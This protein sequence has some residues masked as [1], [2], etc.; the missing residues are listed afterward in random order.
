[1][2][3]IR[4][5]PSIL[6]ADFSR[7]QEHIDEAGNPEWIHVDVMDGQFVPHITMGPVVMRGIK[8]SSPLDVHLMVSD[9]LGQ[10]EAFAKAGASII[11]FHIE[12]LHTVEDVHRCI[13]AIKKQGVRAGLAIKP[14][15]PISGALPFLD[16][17]DLLVIMTVEP[18]V[19][20]QSFMPEMLQKVREIR[21]SHPDLDIEVDGGINEETVK[22]AASAGAN[23]F[24]AGSAVF[25][26]ENPAERV[27]LIRAAAKEAYQERYERER[28][29]N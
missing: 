23:V 28:G 20:G 1:M 17:L 4:I 29:V 24:V 25:K 2:N 27:N 22:L 12:A 14:R 11:T 18:G 7:L 9:P 21:N 6:A 26:F 3:E 15:T 5:A 19:S 13:E 16:E 8:T 10:V